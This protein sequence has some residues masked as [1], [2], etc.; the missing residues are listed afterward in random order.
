MRDA[1]FQATVRPRPDPIEVGASPQVGEIRV[2]LCLQDLAK[3]L[4]RTSM[5]RDEKA[6]QPTEV[7]AEIAQDARQPLSSVLRQLDRRE[8]GRRTLDS[9]PVSATKAISI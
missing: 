7:V 3:I 5:L 1:I 8:R 6:E 2:L 9:C 4:C